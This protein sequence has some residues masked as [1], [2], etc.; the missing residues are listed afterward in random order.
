MSA[1]PSPPAS[2]KYPRITPCI[3]SLLSNLTKGWKLQGKMLFLQRLQKKGLL[4]AGELETRAH[5]VAFTGLWWPPGHRTY[6][7]ACTKP[8][9]SQHSCNRKKHL[10]AAGISTGAGRIESNGTDKSKKK[11]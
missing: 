10:S 1:Q 11:K 5:L 6:S 3:A 8:R 2:L 4:G 9:G 7:C